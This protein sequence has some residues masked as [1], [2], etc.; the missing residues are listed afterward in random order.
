M[1]VTRRFGLQIQIH[2]L[3]ISTIVVQFDSSKDYYSILGAGE[4]ASGSEIER[5]YKRLAVRH[6]PDRGG[7]EEDMKALNE[8]YSVLKDAN[9]RRAYD[10]VR[11]RPVDQLA[12]PYSSPSAQADAITGQ[13]VG[14]MLC[15]A[16]GLVLLMLVRFQWIWFL[17]PLAILA[18]LVI[19]FGV[20]MAHAV[21]LSIRGMF[22]VSHPARAYQFIQE[23]I[24]WSA[25]CGGG[26][27]LYLVLS[28][29]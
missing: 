3:T 20:L 27:G 19:V 14:A 16:V 13:C 4:N 1:R 9:S 28:A 24:F 8:A 2:K 10:F 15:L 18:L 7:S 29:V 5:L 17:W 21:M 11:Q 26:Y 22:A 23:A 12:P 25:V 6:H